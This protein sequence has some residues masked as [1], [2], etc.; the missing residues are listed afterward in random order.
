MKTVLISGASVAGLTAAHWLRSKGYA[1][2]VVECAPALRPGGHALDVRGVA[3]DVLDR[4]GLLEEARRVRTRMRG[5]TM[6]DAEGNELWRSPGT[7]LGGDRSG[8]GDIALLRDDLTRLLYGPTRD[9]VEYVF[10]DSL[11]ALGQDREG[12]HVSFER[13][14]PRTFDLVVGADGLHSEVRRLAFGAERRFVRHL[15]RHLAVFSADNFLGLDDWQ[16]WMRDETARYCLYPARDNT[17]TRATLGFASGPLDHDHRAVEDQK[18]LVAER[19]C[20]LR[21]ETPKL[22]AAMRTAPDFYFDAMARVRMRTWSAGRVVLIGDAGHCPS[23][24]SGQGAGPALVGAY[25]LADE[26]GRAGDDHRAALTRY[27]ARMRTY[28][29]PDRAPTTADPAGSAPEE[30]LERAGN[31]IALDA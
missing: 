19:L 24:M 25:V 26:L 23:S 29:E 7:R 4:M 18:S 1:P 22:L 17:E 16:V 9:D 11:S 13:G 12:V 27:E 31:A 30:P 15:G 5:T 10:G 21:W 28:A 3:L 2:T 8:G 6:L 20:H 14:R